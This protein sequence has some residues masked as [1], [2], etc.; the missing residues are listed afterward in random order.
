MVEVVHNALKFALAHLP[1]TN[2]D[3]GFRHQFRQSVR[4]F[5]DILHV[6][7][8]IIH[9]AAAQN[10]TQDSLAHHQVV[11]FADEGFYR[12]TT[13]GRCGND[14]QIAHT[15]HRHVERTGDWRCRQRQNINV[16]AHCLDALFMPYAET[17]LF[18]DN[19]Q[20]QIL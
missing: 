9:L 15:A 19:Q 11:I 1:V 13:G 4:G 7:I 6:V 5:L 8:Q 12:Q 2:R 18:I 20:A 14:R 3:A 10:F 16:G 17:V